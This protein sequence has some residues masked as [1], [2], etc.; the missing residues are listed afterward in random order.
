MCLAMTQACIKENFPISPNDVTEGEDVTLSMSVSVPEMEVATRGLGEY[1]YDAHPSLWVIVFDQ[2]GYFLQKAQATEQSFVQDGK[3]NLTNF[4]VTLKASPERRILHFVLNYPG[5]LP[6]S[7]H[8]SSYIGGLSVGPDADVYWQRRVLPNG[9]LPAV[10]ENV[11]NPDYEDYVQP[12][13][14]NIPLVRNFAKVIVTV[15]E[16]LNDSFKLEGFTVQ[17]R[18]DKGT[19][20]PYTQGD[21]VDYLNHNY[22]Y[23]TSNGYFGNM[24]EE[25]GYT[26]TKITEGDFVSSDGAVYLYENTFVPGVENVQKTPT[27]II[28]GK[29]GG[30][31]SPVTYYKAD[32]MVQSI[33]PGQ[34]DY[35][36]ILRNFEYELK[37]TNVADHG[38]SLD[39]VTDP[40]TAANNNLSGSLQIRDLTNITN[41]VSGLY[42]SVTDTTLVKQ[43]ALKI[44]YKF[45]SDIE[46]G[47]VDNSRVEVHVE[48]GEVIAKD[49][50]EKYVVTLSS[51]G[52]NGWGTLTVALNPQPAVEKRQT[53]IFYDKKEDG[54]KLRREVLIRYRPKLNMDVDCD[55]NNVAKISG[56]LMTVNISIPDE[57]NEALFPLD[58]AIEANTTAADNNKVKQYLSPANFETL[59]VRVGKTIVSEEKYAGQNSYQYIKKL[60]YDEYSNLPLIDGK[61]VMPVFFVTNTAL[62]ASKVYVRNPYFND[63]SGSFG[64][65]QT[66]PTKNFTALQ[67]ENIRP[68]VDKSVNFKFTMADATSPVTV[69]LIG[70]QPAENSGLT[71]LEGN[72]YQYTSNADGQKIISLK[73][74]NRT[75]VVAVVLSAEG[76]NTAV[77]TA[78]QKE[79]QF[80]D[81]AFPNGV[82]AEEGSPTEFT[83]SM[84]T[85]DPIIVNLTGLEPADDENRLVPVTKADGTY[86]FTP[87]ASGDQELKLKTINDSGTVMVALAADTYDYAPNSKEAERH[88]I[89]TAGKIKFDLHNNT[90]RDIRVYTDSNY[91][92]EIHIF[93]D[94]SENSTNAEDLY[95]DNVKSSQTIYFRYT[96][97]G[98]SYKA[99]ATV[100]TLLSGVTLKFSK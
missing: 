56:S 28:A 7:G 63:A 23:L 99:S 90:S 58:F 18:P 43:E 92:N 80:T 39:D 31:Q 3:D 78:E 21:F 54:S 10:K 44:R 97:G 96:S 11:T 93:E 75:G 33:V 69:T 59:S 19:I 76:Y 32:L 35:A 1:E 49:E 60:S 9:I 95:L 25:V 72:K 67:F 87:S 83:F 85:A 50:T 62:S 47:T 15:D 22:D 5:D 57:L 77:K 52:N 17:Y 79:Y 42:V 38:R 37:I 30:D 29:Y 64:N 55:P 68:G 45:I 71:H 81:L 36:N 73:T 98:T 40:N 82:M 12:Y 27:I 24:P 51:E 46:K 14:T 26:H 4:K 86:S 6:D 100:K 65:L 70:L 16:S 2:Q 89:I 74:L 41:G 84:P 91:T 34:E 13:V 88:V 94:V 20:A 8:E 61:R 53:I 48:E 66:D